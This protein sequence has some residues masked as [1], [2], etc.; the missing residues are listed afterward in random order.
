[1]SSSFRNS[2]LRVK[3]RKF[4]F[5]VFKRAIRIIVRDD[6]SRFW[7]DRFY[8][9]GIDR[10]FYPRFCYWDF[11]GFK[12]FKIEPTSNEYRS[13]DFCVWW[14]L[15]RIKIAEDSLASYT[16]ANEKSFF[17]RFANNFC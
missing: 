17:I 13:T 14:E 1:M 7:Q 3:F 8:F 9:F 16:V 6:Q 12:V 5:I 10:S 15:M 11:L 4:L 2:Y